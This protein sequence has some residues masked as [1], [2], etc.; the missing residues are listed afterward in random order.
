[1]RFIGTVAANIIKKIVDTFTRTTS[2][3]L[4][5]ADSGQ[6]WGATSGVWYA[7]GSQAKSDTAASSYPIASISLAQNA[8]VSASVSLGTGVAFWVTSSGSWWAS[9]SVA[10]ETANPYSC[11]CSTCCNTCTY[12]GGTYPSCSCGSTTVTDY[13]PPY[14]C[15]SG[16]FCFGA[17]STSSGPCCNTSGQVVGSTQATV[18]SSS[19]CNDCTGANCSACGSYSCNCSTCYTYTQNYYLQLLKSVSGTVSEATS[20]VSLGSAAAAIAVS[21]SGDTITAKAYSNTSL[22]SQIGP[23]ITLTPTTPNKGSGVGIIKVPSSYGQNS[24]VDNFNAQT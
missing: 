16:S 17:S 18:Y 19:F 5:Q 22:T 21:T 14:S 10:T 23:T 9:T 7:T 1:M 15:A 8:T 3:S 12:S 4:G 11:N 13:G 6:V 24:V 20:S 2:G